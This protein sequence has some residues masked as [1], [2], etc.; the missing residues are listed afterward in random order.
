MMLALVAGGCK[1]QAEWVE[2]YPGVHCW[3]TY[4]NKP[5]CANCGVVR[6]YDDKNKPCRGI[7]TITLR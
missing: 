2:R 5:S 7:V 1:S 6:R 3:F 4:D